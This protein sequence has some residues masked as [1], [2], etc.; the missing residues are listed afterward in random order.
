MYNSNKSPTRFNNFPVY[1]PDV[2]LQ[3]DTFRAFSRPSSE[4]QWMQWQPLVL[5]SYRD[6]SRTV[7]VVGPVIYL[8]CLLAIF[9]SQTTWTC[10]SEGTYLK[11]CLAITI[12]LSRNWTRSSRFYIQR[13]SLV[14]SLIRWE[15]CFPLIKCWYTKLIT[16]YLLPVTCTTSLW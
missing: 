12:K 13:P 7:F 11:F 10:K 14:S 6:V 8:N 2:Y 1:Y 15:L 4:A 9:F 3:L 5:P 16:V